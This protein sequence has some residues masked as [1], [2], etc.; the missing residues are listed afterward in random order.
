M[1]FRMHGGALVGLDSWMADLPFGEQQPQ[2]SGHA[3]ST[4]EAVPESPVTKTEAELDW[5]ENAARTSS[6]V[7]R[8]DLLLLALGTLGTLLLVGFFAFWR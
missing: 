7:R 4:S 1:S 2:A 6:D 8:T 5:E 3:A